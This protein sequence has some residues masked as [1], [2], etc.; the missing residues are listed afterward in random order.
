MHFVV[1]LH[2]L[3]ADRSNRRRQGMLRR[4]NWVAGPIPAEGAGRDRRARGEIGEH[5]FG[6]GQRGLPAVPRRSP[7]REGHIATLWRVSL[8]GR[9]RHA[10]A[11][12]TFRPPAPSY[13]ASNRPIRKSAARRGHPPSQSRGR[14]PP[15]LKQTVRVRPSRARVRRPTNP[16]WPQILP[17]IVPH[18]FRERPG[19]VEK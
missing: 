9:R 11:P 2:R 18:L 1:R 14:P 10:P 7:S 8:S 12:Y 17:S 16:R 3:E 19:D 15:P 13:S 4:L 5:G 6:E